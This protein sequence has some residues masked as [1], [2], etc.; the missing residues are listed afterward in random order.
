VDK[1]GP[2]SSVL[3]IILLAVLF[4]LAMDYEVFLVSRIREAYVHQRQP[5]RAVHEGA[6]HSARVVTAAALI[7][8]AVFASFLRTESLML[9]QIALALAIGVAL[10]AFVI[11]MTFVPAVL[12]LTRHAAWWLPRPLARLL[13]DLDIEG[14]KLRARTEEHT[15]ATVHQLHETAA[16]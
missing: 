13:P 2:V 9:K 10:D 14:E 8:I 12:A 1:A 11:R 6:R 5:L 16:R 4:G 7:M 15:G 3:P